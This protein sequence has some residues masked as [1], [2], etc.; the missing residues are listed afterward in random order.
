MVVGDGE[1]VVVGAVGGGGG[2]GG[3]LAMSRRYPAAIRVAGDTGDEMLVSVRPVQ[4]MV[5]SPTMIP[6][7]IVELTTCCWLLKPM[8]T[9]V[10]GRSR[11]VA[12]R[13][14]PA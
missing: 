6:N 7:E 12:P 4:R 10:T 11:P 8:L 3:L 2:G 13:C 9:Q 14:Q 5:H 1:A